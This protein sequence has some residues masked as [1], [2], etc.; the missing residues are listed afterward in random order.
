MVSRKSWPT[1]FIKVREAKMMIRQQTI[2]PGCRENITVRLSAFPTE[3]LHFYAPCPRCGT[4]MRGFIE[5]GDELESFRM[6]I[7]GGF[8]S[9]DGKDYPVVT[10][11]PSLPMKIDP[12][13]LA[14]PWGGPSMAFVRLAGDNIEL[15]MEAS[16]R[17]AGALQVRVK[18]IRA[19][20]YYVDGTAEDYWNYMEREFGWLIGNARHDLA[21]HGTAHHL[22]QVWLMM[23]VA[24]PWV[25]AE[26]SEALQTVVSVH[27][28][29][30]SVPG[31]CDLMEQLENRG[32]LL[33]ADRA[34]LD[35]SRVLVRSAAAWRSGYIR[36]GMPESTVSDLEQLILP[37]DEFARLRDTYQQVYEAVCQTL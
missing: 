19:L 25:T 33:G 4:P 36:L 15:L 35:A 27:A 21:R 3:R 16:S 8:A 26:A 1:E 10:V 32:D 18:V 20:E 23:F 6:E 5:G 17:I 12:T 34:L 24:G 13:G 29:G 7:D 28:A 22:W 2:C 14:Q 9:P 30:M 31:Y 11:D 37:Q